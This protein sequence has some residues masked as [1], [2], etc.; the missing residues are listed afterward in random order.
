METKI[1]DNQESLY[2]KIKRTYNETLILLE[3]L[4]NLNLERRGQTSSLSLTNMKKPYLTNK[5][6]LNRLELYKLFLT[7]ASECKT[8][9][10][11][12]IPFPDL[13]LKNSRGFSITKK[14][15][16]VFCLN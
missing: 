9:K 14:E 6:R 2:D 4:K 11:G 5:S 3:E 7:R 15:L 12:I 10:G 16:G 13:F 1:T 8:T